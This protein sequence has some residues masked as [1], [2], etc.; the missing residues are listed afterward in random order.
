MF[1]YTLI[2]PFSIKDFG[3]MIRSFDL[4]WG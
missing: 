4:S 1:D 2:K 3:F